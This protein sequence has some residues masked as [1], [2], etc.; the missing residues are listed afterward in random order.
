[1]RDDLSQAASHDLSSGHSYP[2]LDC[3]G[4]STVT[5]LFDTLL[6][7]GG[8]ECSYTPGLCH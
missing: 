6:S 7:A 3:R 4:C 1:M 2:D 8:T 5:L